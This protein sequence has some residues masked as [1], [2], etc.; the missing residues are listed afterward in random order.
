MSKI[1]A[2]FGATGKQG[3]SVVRSILADPVLSKEWK[4]RGITRDATKPAAKALEARGV[5]VVTADM[6]SQASAAPGV[7]GAHTVFL[8]TNFWETAS[9]D[10]ERSEGIAVTDA[11]KAA[12]VKHIIFSSLINVT[13]ATSGRLTNMKHFD[14]KNEIEKYIL[15]SGI[16]ST[17][18]LPGMFMSSLVDFLNKNPD[19]GSYGLALPVSGDRA[20]LPVFDAE[21][22]TGTFVKPA[23]RDPSPSGKHIIAAAE[24]LSP[25][26]LISQFTEATGKKASFSQVPV[27]VF[28]GFLPEVVAGELTENMLLLE[29]VGYYAGADLK[30]SLD[31]LGDEKPATWREFAAANKEKWA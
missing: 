18:V 11:S 1:L 7:K 27:D 30:P 12:G 8:V 28:K 15:K 4:I 6:S 16:P 9:A 31:L 20:K 26:E 21:K 22:D 10:K 5:E 29:D 25:N 14:T 13:E 23:L 19:D 17:F 2:V 24:Y 3:G